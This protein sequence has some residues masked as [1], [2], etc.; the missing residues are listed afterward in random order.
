L[1]KTYFGKFE[2]SE[3]SAWTISLPEIRNDDL[4]VRTGDWVVFKVDDISSTSLQSNTVRQILKLVQVPKSEV[5][6]EL[7]TRDLPEF[8]KDYT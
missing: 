3:A 2:P 7:V 8:P 1:A 6:N 4:L 5:E